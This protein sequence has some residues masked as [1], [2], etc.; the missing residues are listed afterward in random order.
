MRL[1]S[2]DDCSHRVRQ[3]NVPLKEK[4]DQILAWIDMPLETRP[5]FITGTGHVSLTTVLIE[6]AYYSVRA[7]P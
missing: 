3:D 6:M 1:L 5:Q 2:R 7:L 4:L